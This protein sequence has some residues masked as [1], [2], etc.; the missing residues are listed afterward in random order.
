MF[1]WCKLSCK[2]IGYILAAAG[3]AVILLTLVPIWVLLGI[4]GLALIVLGLSLIL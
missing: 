1:K 3:A 2:T 4:V